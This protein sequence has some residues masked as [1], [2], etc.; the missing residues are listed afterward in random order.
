MIPHQRAW[1][2]RVY[3][4]FIPQWT[5]YLIPV[6]WT[7]MVVIHSAICWYLWVDIYP[8]TKCIWS[9]WPFSQWRHSCLLHIA[10]NLC[11]SSLD[12][13]DDIH[14]RSHSFPFIHPREVFLAWCWVITRPLS[15]CGVILLSLPSEVGLT[16]V[17][18]VHLSH[19]WQTP[20]HKGTPASDAMRRRQLWCRMHEC[21]CWSLTLYEG[22]SVAIWCTTL[23]GLS[24]HLSVIF[25]FPWKASALTRTRLPSFKP[26]V[27]IF[28]S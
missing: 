15:S 20:R 17:E 11:P 19:S 25:L 6:L 21:L 26:T 28:Q 8:S 9:C 23:W 18:L 2:S 24:S 7:V 4:H 10:W 27:P 5:C 3:T 14:G 13:L 12:T 22:M 1:H 16:G